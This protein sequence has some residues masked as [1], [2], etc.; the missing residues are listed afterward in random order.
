MQRQRESG[1]LA[2]Q[3]PVVNST[4]LGKRK[5]DVDLTLDERQSKLP[6]FEPRDIVD[7]TQDGFGMNH[8]ADFNIHD[9]PGPQLR[10]DD[11][12]DVIFDD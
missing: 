11:D 9:A 5:A 2:S 4:A 1:I 7:L 8:E 3:P 6:R 12:E 10:Y